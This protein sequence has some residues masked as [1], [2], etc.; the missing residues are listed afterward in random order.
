MITD[1]ISNYIDAQ[2]RVLDALDPTE[3]AG[4]ITVVKQAHAAN[5]QIFVCG[6]GGNA[7]NAAHFVTDLGKNSSEAMPTPF[8]VL[9]INDNVSWLTAIGNDY[10]FNDVFVHQLRNYAQPG[11]LLM[12]SSV[13]GNS[14]NVVAAL[15]WARDRGLVTVALVGAKKGRAAAVAEHVVV[16][17]DTHYGRVEDVQ[18]HILHMLCYAFVEM[19]M[20]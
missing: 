3:I 8:R 6:N 7:A 12:T 18:M 13:S 2:R 20:L 19:P 17:Q 16:V 15:E 10:N 5:R 14:P 4:L 11:D 9:S 1:W